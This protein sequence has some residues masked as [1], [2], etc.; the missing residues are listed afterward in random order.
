MR[1]FVLT[2]ISFQALSI[3]VKMNVATQVLR[4]VFAQRQF[5]LLDKYTAASFCLPGWQRECG[6]G[7]LP[8]RQCPQPPQHPGCHHSRSHPLLVKHESL[9]RRVSPTDTHT[10]NLLTFRNEVWMLRPYSPLAT[11]SLLLTSFT[12]TS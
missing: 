12:F 3:F 9:H 7:G 4:K 8:R 10:Y 11:D 1:I 5:L 6:E 2:E